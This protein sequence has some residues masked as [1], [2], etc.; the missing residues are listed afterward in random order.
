MFGGQNDYINNLVTEAKEGDSNAFGVIFAF[1][2]EEIY[3]HCKK[4]LSKEYDIQD[5][6]LNTYCSA[7]KRLD[8]LGN[9]KHIEKWLFLICEGHITTFLK[10]QGVTRIEAKTLAKEARKTSKK[11]S[12]S[13][14]N[15]EQILESV[16]ILVGADTNTLPL[17]A[18][19]S[20]HQYRNNRLMFQRG[21]LL[22]ALLALILIP[23]FSLS[24][25]MDV[26]LIPGS[27]NGDFEKFAINVKTIV[28]VDYIVGTLDSDKVTIM[29]ENDKMYTAYITGNGTF[30]VTTTILNRKSVTKTI[31]IND[32]D[33]TPPV[34]SNYY[35][36]RG[37]LMVVAEDDR[38]GIDFEKT[39]ITQLSN[40]NV[41]GPIEYD[42]ENGLIR[43]PYIQGDSA[44]TIVDKEGNQKS[45]TIN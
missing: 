9:A 36:D 14:N 30:T 44:L 27:Y 29:M 38:S 24:P 3:K 13:L 5:V 25:S 43:L 26:T 2:Y 16:L 39:I 18:L 45:Y 23:F 6:M 1:S 28:P 40:G 22:V 4:Y 19:L 37:D 7:Y 42:E 10:K 32:F 11:T 41:F 20:Y 31:I 17:E 12:I 34:V 33:V 15:A 21:L 35:L 8:Q